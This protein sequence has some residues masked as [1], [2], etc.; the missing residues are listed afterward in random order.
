MLRITVSFLE[1]KFCLACFLYFCVSFQARDMIYSG[2]MDTKFSTSCYSTFTRNNWRQGEML[3]KPF[4]TTLQRTT[5]MEV[6]FSVIVFEA[7]ILSLTDSKSHFVNSSSSCVHIFIEISGILL[8]LLLSLDKM[9]RCRK[10][11]GPDTAT[12][13][14]R[15]HCWLWLGCLPRDLLNFIRSCSNNHV[16]ELI[17]VEC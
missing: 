15:A 2:S 3:F 8:Q 11:E 5:H 10:V 14:K 12:L 7:K 16:P 9:R 13:K 17:R 6:S 1:N 4:N